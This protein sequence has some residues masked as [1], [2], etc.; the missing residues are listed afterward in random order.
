MQNTFQRL[1]I[2]FLRV[3]TC[4]LGPREDISIL[5]AAPVL[6]CLEGLISSLLLSFVVTEEHPGTEAGRKLLYLLLF[7]TAFHHA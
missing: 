3:P 4:A 2:A 7:P 5:T 6:A 1:K